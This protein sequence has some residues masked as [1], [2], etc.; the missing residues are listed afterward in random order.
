MS[1][2]QKQW[3][4]YIDTAHDPFYNMAMDEVLLHS[5]KGLGAP[6]IRMYD[7]DCPSVSIGYVQHYDAA[8]ND[9]YTVVRRPTG[10]GVVYHD[11][12]LTYTAIVRLMIR[13]ANL[14]E[15]ILSYF[16]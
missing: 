2:P 5:A 9:K 14:T 3:Y 11:N 8:P 1:T 12:D 13:S 15:L 10:G 16:P 6:L 4:L 7:W